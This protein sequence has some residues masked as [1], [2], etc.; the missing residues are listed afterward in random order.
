MRI[1][2]AGGLNN[3]ILLIDSYGLAISYG[4]AKKTPE[5]E[6]IKI[7][8]IANIPN[9]PWNILKSIC[10]LK[11]FTYV[12]NSTVKL[13]FSFLLKS[14]FVNEFDAG[15]FNICPSLLKVEPWHGQV[16]FPSFTLLIWQP[17]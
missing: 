2:D 3:K 1:K 12:F 8:A 4:I 9:E 16:M 11:S 14:N 7:L 5:S 15:P 6:Q 13:P 10:V 17:K